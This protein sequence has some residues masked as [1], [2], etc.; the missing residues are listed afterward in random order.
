MPIA[1][2]SSVA[3]DILLKVCIM[4]SKFGLFTSQY[5]LWCEYGE[6][7]T[8]CVQSCAED[9]RDEGTLLVFS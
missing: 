8:A 6:I 3:I 1:V 2:H 5:T 9:H 4:W 7:E